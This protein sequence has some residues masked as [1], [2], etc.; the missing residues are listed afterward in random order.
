MD[1]AETVAVFWNTE[2]QIFLEEGNNFR[3]KYKDTSTIKVQ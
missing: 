1:L 3:P 2:L